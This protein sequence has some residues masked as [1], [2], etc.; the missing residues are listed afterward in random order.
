MSTISKNY[1]YF[2]K[3]HEYKTE[4]NKNKACPICLGSIHEPPKLPKVDKAVPSRARFSKRHVVSIKKKSPEIK[5]VA[6]TNGGD[7]HPIHFGC[8]KPHLE[9]TNQCPSCK[10]ICDDSKITPWH[11]KVVRI[12]KGIPQGRAK[13]P[14]LGAARGLISAGVGS[15]LGIFPS[16]IMNTAHRI[17]PL[18]P[19]LLKLALAVML[20]YR[21]YVFIKT[22]R[23][24]GFDDRNAPQLSVIAG[25]AAAFFNL[26]YNLGIALGIVPMT[27]ST[28]L[29]SNYQRYESYFTALGVLSTTMLISYLWKVNKPTASLS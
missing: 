14:L 15:F 8:L 4:E 10:M 16:L 21:S 20:V 3:P 19:E 2:L 25:L 18:P 28:L 5:M 11:Q 17:Q 24:I 9:K 26:D 22:T 13:G 27:I 12:L 7:K 23:I 29:N 6:H 1:Y